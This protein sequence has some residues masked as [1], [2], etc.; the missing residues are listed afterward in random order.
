VGWWLAGKPKYSEK[1]CPSATL[2]TTN[3]IWPE[4][5]RTRAAAVGSQRLTAWAMAL[6][7]SDDCFRTHFSAP[8]LHIGTQRSEGTS[9]V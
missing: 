2:F 4:R 5:A 6:P 9:V 7:F 1:I 8:S 3:P